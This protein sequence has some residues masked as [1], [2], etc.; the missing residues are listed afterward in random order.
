MAR[1]WVKRVNFTP[2]NTTDD[3]VTLISAANRRLRVLGVYAN[4][5]GASSAP[6]AL[7]VSRVATAGI[8]PVALLFRQRPIIMTNRPLRSPLQLRG[9]H[10][11]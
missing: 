5:G 11:L 10:S 8:T 1:Y 9:V 7:S 4:G 6:Q 2:A 3:V